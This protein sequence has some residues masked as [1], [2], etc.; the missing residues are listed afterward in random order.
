MEDKLEYPGSPVSNGLQ[1]SCGDTPPPG[2]PT[3]SKLFPQMNDDNNE[4]FRPSGKVVLAAMTYN[5]AGI[6]TGTLRE[7]RHGTF[8][9]NSRTILLQVHYNIMGHMG[10]IILLGTKK[11]LEE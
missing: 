9:K 4:K 2:T 3:T 1:I 11:I 8:L 6:S 5:K 7:T 10:I